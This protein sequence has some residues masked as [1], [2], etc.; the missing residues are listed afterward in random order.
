MSKARKPDV[1]FRHHPARAVAG[2]IVAVSMTT[3]V[4][5][6]PWLGLLALIPLAWAGWVWRAGTDA[7]TDG[8]RVRGL[9]AARHIP[10][11]RVDSVTAHGRAQVVATLSDGA[12][13]PL[14]AVTAADLPRLAN[15]GDRTL[16]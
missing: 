5:V 7:G 2:V 13:L 10:W 12:R 8:L 9:L 4:T 6:S 14:T 15:A 1:Q 3:L 16:G 11:S